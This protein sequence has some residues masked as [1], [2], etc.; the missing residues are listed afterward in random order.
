MLDIVVLYNE[1]NVYSF[2]PVGSI[3]GA[4]LFVPGTHVLAVTVAILNT[5]VEQSAAKAK[6]SEE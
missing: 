1:S 6:H 4:W 5:S 3:Y 2:V